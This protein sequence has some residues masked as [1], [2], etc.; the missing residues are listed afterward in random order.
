MRPGM[1][2]AGP[3]P[4][5]IILQRPGMPRMMSPQG[6]VISPGQSPQYMQVYNHCLIRQTTDQQLIVNVS[7]DALNIYV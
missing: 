3:Q 1:V 5:G 7:L 6:H 2:G 4:G